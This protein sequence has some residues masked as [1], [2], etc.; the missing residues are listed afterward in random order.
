MLTKEALQIIAELTIN[1]GTPIGQ[2]IHTLGLQQLQQRILQEIAQSKPYTSG[3]EGDIYRLEIDGKE[4]IIVKK[5]YHI[6][7]KEHVFQK[8]AF[9]IASE[10]SEQG[11]GIIAVPEL[12][13]HFLDDS[14]EYIVMEYIHGKTLYSLI[15]EQLVTKTILPVFEKNRG[16]LDSAIT[17]R[18]KELIDHY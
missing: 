5:R 10:L 16:D 14:N 6:S 7:E 4:Y 1:S 2:Y 11:N 17:E 13:S 8:K 3:T 18:F 9:G 12:F 15:L